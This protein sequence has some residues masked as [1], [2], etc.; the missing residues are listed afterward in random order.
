MEIGNNYDVT[1]TSGKKEDI[2]VLE[3]V[4]ESGTF[5]RSILIYINHT[6]DS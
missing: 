4:L 6:N 3:L 5:W 1:A 2:L